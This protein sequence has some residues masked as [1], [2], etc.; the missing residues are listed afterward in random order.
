MVHR[1]GV[2][3]F[4]LLA[5]CS[6]SPSAANEDAGAPLDGGGDVG[7]I[8]AQPDAATIA[9]RKCTPI[10]NVPDPLDIHGTISDGTSLQA[11]GLAG[12]TVDLVADDE[13]VLATATTAA[14][15]TYTLAAVPTGGKPLK[16]RVRAKMTGYTTGSIRPVWG[17]FTHLSSFTLYP[18]SVHQ[19]AARAVGK[20]YDPANAIFEV[21]LRNCNSGNPQDGL[22]GATFAFTPG[23]GMAYVDATGNPVKS[24]SA[25]VAPGG[26][27]IDFAVPPGPVELR[28]TY[29]GAT[30]K[31]ALASH[32]GEFHIVL[33]YP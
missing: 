17:E 11:A 7:S 14:D 26:V 33:D 31:L 30:T 29:A 9:D 15:G 22:A 19:Q 2:G 8:D 16:A 28:T 13:T 25:T 21:S 6:S 3:L 12:A 32:A 24:L 10:A 5:G 23:S 20:T 18:P 27:G 4:V 1:I